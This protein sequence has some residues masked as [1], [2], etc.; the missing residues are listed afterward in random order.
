[1]GSGILVFNGPDPRSPCPRHKS[2]AVHI[3]IAPLG[4]SWERGLGEP[5]TPPPPRYATPS[6]FQCCSSQGACSEP[7][8][9]PAQC[10]SC[11]LFSMCIPSLVMSAHRTFDA[12]LA[13]LPTY[14][15]N[16]L[17]VG[18]GLFFLRDY[19]QLYCVEVSL[20]TVLH[21]ACWVTHKLRQS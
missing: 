8:G 13:S 7:L 12:A 19:C 14:W 10:V 9:P 3:S 5:A 17:K 20:I 16:D 2:N 1:M 6:G 4:L 15:Y 11:L 18:K 21:M